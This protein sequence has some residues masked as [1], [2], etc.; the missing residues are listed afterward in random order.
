MQ[1]RLF[2]G[3]HPT[4]MA[5]N[6][7][8]LA[9]HSISALDSRWALYRRRIGSSSRCTEHLYL[10]CACQALTASCRLLAL[11]WA[12]EMLSIMLF[13]CQ[14]AV[15]R[16]QCSKTCTCDQAESFDQPACVQSKESSLSETMKATG[17]MLLLLSCPA[18]S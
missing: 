7:A 13:L 1:K 17:Q 3:H 11:Q 14:W 18:V 15:R 2:C 16:C 9:F 10:V 4:F 8:V 5:L 12:T 6:C